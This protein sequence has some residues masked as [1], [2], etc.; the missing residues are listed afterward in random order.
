MQQSM[1]AFAG[2][3]GVTSTMFAHD[4][5]TPTQGCDAHPNGG[6]PEVSD[7]I[8]GFIEFYASSLAVPARR[9]IND[10]QVR[11]GAALFNEAQCAACH[12][13][14]HV[15][16]E[17][18]DRPDLS[19]QEIWP[20]TDLLLH[21]MGPGLADHRDEFL[22]SGTE[23]RTPPLWGIGLA[24]RVNPRAGFLHDGRARTL[25]EA[26]LWH[27]GEARGAADTYRA[28]ARD[29]RDALIRFLESL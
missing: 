25:E 20:Y 15:T 9:D 23:W 28:L 21:D 8:A 7:K 12:T 24:L 1:A 3:L 13:P 4:D 16:G 6:V 5:C 19:N 22:A 26:I 17:V 29:D 2:D 18:A 27:D 14:R 11:A 10:A